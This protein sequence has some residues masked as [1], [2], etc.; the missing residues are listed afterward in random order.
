MANTVKKITKDNRFEDIMA[1]LNGDTVKYGTTLEIAKEFIAHERELLA[2]KNSSED[3]K[4]TQ[5]QLDNARYKELIKDFLMGQTEGLTVTQ[6]TKSVPEL[7]DFSNQKVARLVRDM[8]DA[9]IVT[10]ET[11]KGRALFSIA[12]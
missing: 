8:L 4:P 3:K 6:I 2:R 7:A 9:G 10:K 1:L 11:V 12:Q 5:T